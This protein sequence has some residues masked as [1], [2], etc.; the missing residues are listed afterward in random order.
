[1]ENSRA[2]KYMR[3]VKWEIENWSSDDIN[4]VRFHNT[5]THSFVKPVANLYVA[6]QDANCMRVTPVISNYR[7]SYVNNC[8]GYIRTV[9]SCD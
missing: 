3:W 5:L 6:N 4:N 7:C 2:V 8:D 9:S 1:M